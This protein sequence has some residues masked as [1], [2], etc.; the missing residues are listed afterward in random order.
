MG[1]MEDLD[2][3]DPGSYSD[4]DEGETALYTPSRSRVTDPNGHQIF[5]YLDYR[6]YLR[7]YYQAKKAEG[8]GFSFRQFSRRAQLKSPN[9]LK[10]VME[11]QRNLSPAMAERF[12]IACGLGDDKLAYFVDL[13]AFNQA[14]SS[15]ERNACYA[16]LTRHRRYRT[17][18]ALDLAHAE[19]YASWYMPAIRELAVRDDFRDDPEWI[20]RTVLPPIS[21]TEAA[22]AMNTLLELG[23]LVRTEDGKVRQGEALVSTGPETIGLHV[24]NYHRAMMERA[25]ESIDLVPSERRDISS[26]TL[27]L[28]ESGYQSMKQR[29]QQF[30]REL[31]E[32]SELEASPRRVVQINFQMFPLSSGD[33]EGE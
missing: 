11:G 14:K 9:Y 3:D 18:H 7:D 30:R 33:E 27:C 1:P 19:Y 5:A 6:A 16:R 10:L 2:R 13:V 23:L 12:G 15:T 31:L 17:V 21:R 8:R 25:A 24:G 28:S 20:A 32:L 22:R 29:I 4:S 26:L